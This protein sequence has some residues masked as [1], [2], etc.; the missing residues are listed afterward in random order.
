MDLGLLCVYAVATLW[1]GF[2]WAVIV[3]PLVVLAV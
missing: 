1:F 2:V 3:I